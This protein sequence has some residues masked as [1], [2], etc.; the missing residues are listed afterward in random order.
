MRPSPIRS[1]SLPA[2]AAAIA[3][4][5]ASALSDCTRELRE[6]RKLR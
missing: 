4:H 3:C 2:L 6:L 1:I 5:E